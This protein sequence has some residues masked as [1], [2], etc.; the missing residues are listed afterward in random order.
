MSHGLKDEL[1]SLKNR[2]EVIE[3]QLTGQLKEIEARDE[4]WKRMEK[5]LEAIEKSQGEIVKLNI[6]GKVYSIAVSTIKKFPDSLLA[7]LLESG[8]V[9]PNEEIFFDRS[10]GTFDLILEYIRNGQLNFNKFNEDQLHKLKADAE[11]F[12]IF[13][14]EMTLDERLKDIEFISYEY[15]GPYVYNGQ[16]SGAGGVEDLKDKTCNHGICANTP[17]W[18]IIELNGIWEFDTLMIGGW[19][20]NTSLWYPDN[21]AGAS[22]QTSLDKQSW[23]TVGTIPSGYGTTIATVKLSKSSAHYIKFT[24]TSYVGIGYLYIK[25]LE[26]K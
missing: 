1:F 5:K 16:T 13:D 10:P 12:G 8:R 20:G 17:G 24:Y 25:K 22:I 14:L 18:I 15:S 6:G 4:K 19:K 26:A 3:N 23:K 11:Y 9:D 21:G 7:K 2:L